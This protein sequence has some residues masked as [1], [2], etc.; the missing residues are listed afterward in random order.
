MVVA[1]LFSPDSVLTMRLSAL[2]NMYETD[3]VY[4][5]NAQVNIIEENALPITLYYKGNGIYKNDSLIPEPGKNYQ[6]NVIA[7]DYPSLTS[8]CRLPALNN[9][10]II[11]S[12]KDSVGID[13]EGEYFSE[14]QI[15][16]SDNPSQKN[17]YEIRLSAVFDTSTYFPYRSVEIFGNDPVIENENDL[18]YYPSSFVFSD[19]LINGSIYNLRLNY[20]IPVSITNGTVNTKHKLYMRFNCISEEYYQFKKKLFRHFATQIG[21]IWEPAEPA[22][23]YSNINGGYGIF[24]GYCGV[25]DT[26]K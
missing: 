16:I 8:N 9:K 19:E 7:A 5:Q 2:Q 25:T 15:Q 11:L 14:L 17:Y 21:G 18:Q 24:A 3:I 20:H 13:Q 12:T 4:I 6:L 23:M 10:P 1:C 26:I 22:Q